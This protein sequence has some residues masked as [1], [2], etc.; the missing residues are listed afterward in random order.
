MSEEV[1]VGADRG[2]RLVP[3]RS[4]RIPG[5]SDQHSGLQAQVRLE[6]WRRAHVCAREGREGASP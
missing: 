1:D 6:R 2:W 4:R 3:L 5:D